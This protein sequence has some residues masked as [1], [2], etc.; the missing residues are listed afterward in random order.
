MRQYFVIN[1]NNNN[2]N[3]DLTNFN[4]LVIYDWSIPY[5]F[6]NIYSYNNSFNIDGNIY[7]ILIKN[8]D[9]NFLKSQIETQIAGTTITFDIPTFKTTISRAA[10]YDLV[11]TP[12][13]DLLGFTSTQTLTGQN[14]YTSSNVY[15]LNKHIDNVYIN[16]DNLHNILNYKP[17]NINNYT[18][19]YI[20]N[21]NTGNF[22]FGNT[23]TNINNNDIVLSINPNSNYIPNITCNLHDY[24]NNIINVNGQ[25]VIL[26][27]YIE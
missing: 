14:S 17:L 21:I 23:I 5:T 9:I 16:S 6:Y 2:L 25:N 20:N 24:Y 11:Y 1:S 27:C 8:Y 10:N 12:F 19:G 13:L 18:H 4:K 15:N 22:I 7:T 26:F 3:V